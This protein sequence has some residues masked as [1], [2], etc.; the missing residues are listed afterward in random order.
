[1]V[2][3]MFLDEKPPTELLLCGGI[4]VKTEGNLHFDADE[5]DQQWENNEEEDDEGEGNECFAIIFS[6]F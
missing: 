1:M 3:C 5:R 2:L 6:F 4:T